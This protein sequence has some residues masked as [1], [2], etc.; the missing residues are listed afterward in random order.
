MTD[1][2]RLL[3]EEGVGIEK[4]QRRNS[5]KFKFRCRGRN[6]LKFKCRRIHD[7]VDLDISIQLKDNASDKNEDGNDKD[8]KE[9]SKEIVKELALDIILSKA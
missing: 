3:C 5:V 4:L 2:S 7:D 1:L 8:W 6:L 9:E